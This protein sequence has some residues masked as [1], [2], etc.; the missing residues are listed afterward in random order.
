MLECALIAF[1]SKEMDTQ[2]W[3]FEGSWYNTELGQG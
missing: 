1:L 2:V 3:I